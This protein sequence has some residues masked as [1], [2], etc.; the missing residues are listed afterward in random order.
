MVRLSFTEAQLQARKR[1]L[2]RFRRLE[3]LGVFLVLCAVAS[4]MLAL[5]P[6]QDRRHSDLTTA[7]YAVLA[8][9]A[10]QSAIVTRVGFGLIM[11]PRSLLKRAAPFRHGWFITAATPVAVLCLLTPW[12]LAGEFDD[13]RGTSAWLTGLLLFLLLASA[14]I[15]GPIVL[16]AVL[17]PIELLIRGLARVVIGRSKS[18]RSEGI[19]HIR[20][21]GFITYLVAMCLLIGGTA[22]I[23]TPQQRGSVWLVVLGFTGNEGVEHPWLLWVGRVMFYGFLAIIIWGLYGERRQKRKE[24]ERQE[25]ER[26]E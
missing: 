8:I 6:E 20:L 12:I 14:T 9:L 21:A 23:A 15:S 3:P 11:E 26:G 2:A 18:E 16:V 22:N 7:F 4:I 5:P 1:A 10:M 17:L 24:L 25:E 13:R 19:G